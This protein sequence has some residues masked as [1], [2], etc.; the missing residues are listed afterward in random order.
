[1]REFGGN[2][3]TEKMMELYS[4]EAYLRKINTMRHCYTL[5]SKAR[6]KR[7]RPNIKYC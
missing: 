7:E 6:D 1:M 4:T 5:T 2:K 3:E